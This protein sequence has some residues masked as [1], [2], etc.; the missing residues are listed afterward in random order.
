MRA[1][2]RV[3]LP[4]NVAKTVLH[5]AIEAVKPLRA[6]FWCTP[7][8]GSAVS[9]C[10][11]YQTAVSRNRNEPAPCSLGAHLQLCRNSDDVAPVEVVEVFAEAERKFRALMN[12]LHMKMKC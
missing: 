11:A 8:V 4:R 3:M 5:A 9:R 10:F 1:A 7:L 2:N 12:E 6:E